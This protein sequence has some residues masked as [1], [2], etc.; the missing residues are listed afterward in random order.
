MKVYA[1]ILLLIFSC[2][3]LKAGSA[4]H[5]VASA[6]MALFETGTS[7]DAEKSCCSN[8]GSDSEKEGCCS[9]ENCSCTCCVHLVYLDLQ[10]A[11]KTWANS[12]F[13]LVNTTYEFT[14]EFDWINGCFHPPLNV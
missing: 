8:S 10:Q 13:Q 9:G 7:C 6:S 4:I 5:W 11:K 1:Y 14:Y 12:N 2:N 3:T